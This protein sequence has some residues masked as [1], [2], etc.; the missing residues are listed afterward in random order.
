MDEIDNMKY[1]KPYFFIR[2]NFI[3]KKLRDERSLQYSKPY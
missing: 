1:F 3:A 2:D